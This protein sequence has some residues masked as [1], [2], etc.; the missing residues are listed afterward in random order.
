MNH[1]FDF[2]ELSLQGAYLI[3][4]FESYDNRG[5]FIKDFSEEIYQ[6]NGINHTSKEIFYTTS[7]KG[8]IRAL[9]FQRIKQ[10]AKIVRC[11]S[12]EIFDVIVDLRIKSQTFGKWLGFYL[13]EQNHKM[14][15]IPKNFAHGYLVIKPSVVAYNCSEDF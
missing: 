12:G 7:K 10:Q 6:K 1:N 8:V 11:I 15:Y 2:E 5:S 13:T 9:H 14:I 3:K 4:P